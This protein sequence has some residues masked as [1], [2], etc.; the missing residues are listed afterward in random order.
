MAV[1]AA[2]FKTLIVSI[3]AGLISPSGLLATVELPDAL[4]VFIGIPSTTING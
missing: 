1:E 3:S 2:S 4:P